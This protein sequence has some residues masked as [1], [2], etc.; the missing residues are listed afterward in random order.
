MKV[1][2]GSDTSLRAAPGTLETP[3]NRD[4]GTLDTCSDKSD[5]PQLYQSVFSS[6]G[7]LG[8]LVP[9]KSFPL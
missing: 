7:I 3:S 5:C 4:T 8:S 2:T 6:S 9:I 1:P